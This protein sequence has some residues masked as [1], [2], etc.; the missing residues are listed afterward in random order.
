MTL[1]LPAVLD[2]LEAL[3]GRPARPVP[4][5]AL[6]WILWENAAYLVP[7][8]RRKQA[9][10]A[11]RQLTGLSAAG[12]L[13]E[14]RVKKLLDIA[15]RVQSEFEGD[16]QKA[17]RL[18]LPKARSAL[19]KFPG[20]GAPGADKILLFTGT[21]ALAALESN[22]LRALTRLGLAHEGKS[23]AATYASAMRALEPHLERGCPFLMRAF[24]LL[25]VHGRELCKNSRPLCETCPL[26]GECPSAE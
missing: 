26:A 24:A 10:V 6:D 7:D 9:F 23:Y 19:R 11:L 8:E 2:Q 18:P 12:M 22:G 20:I 1:E 4:K 25:R 5:T 17:L 3:H 21:H 13:P 14:L 15:E 16:L